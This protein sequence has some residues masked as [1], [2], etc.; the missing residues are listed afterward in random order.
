MSFHPLIND[1]PPPFRVNRVGYIKIDP[2]DIERIARRV[3][4]LLKENSARSTETY[5]A[6]CQ[7]ATD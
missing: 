5:M 2:E 6:Q 1:P 3:I 4:E 7:A